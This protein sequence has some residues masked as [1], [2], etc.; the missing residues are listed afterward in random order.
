MKVEIIK[1][2][3][4][5]NVYYLKGILDNLDIVDSLRKETINNISP[6]MTRITRVYGQMTEFNFF[7]NHPLFH[8]FLKLIEAEIKYVTNGLNYF[9]IFDAW[10][11]KYSKG[12]YATL[13]DHKKCNGFSGILY[14]DDEGPGTIFPELNIHESDKKG[15]FVLFS[16]CLLHSVPE[17]LGEKERVTI[18]FNCNIKEPW[19]DIVK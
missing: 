4:P 11:N 6:K 12:D 14:T 19:D 9:N 5:N 1:T 7:C 10:G 3:L 16:P 8:S 2:I 13:H 18:A 15:K 17:Y